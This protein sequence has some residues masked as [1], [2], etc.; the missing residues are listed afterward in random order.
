MTELDLLSRISKTSN[1]SILP[2]T[3]RIQFLSKLRRRAFTSTDS[4]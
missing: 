4:R 3:D 2:V 1:E